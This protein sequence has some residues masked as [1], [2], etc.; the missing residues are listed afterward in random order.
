VRVQNLAVGNRKSGGGAT[1]MCSISLNDQIEIR[2][3]RCVVQGDG[4][5]TNARRLVTL[6]TLLVT[7]RDWSPRVRRRGGVERRKP[8]FV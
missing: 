5:E 4:K 7:L 1:V 3:T 8:L 2:V 6:P